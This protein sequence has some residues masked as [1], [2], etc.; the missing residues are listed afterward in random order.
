M[1]QRL[2]SLLLRTYPRAFRR[3]HGDEFRA[4]ILAQRRRAGSGLVAGV[5]FWL[6]TLPDLVLAAT[7]L[8]RSSRDGIDDPGT[9]HPRAALPGGGDLLHSLLHDA[10]FAARALRATPL[11][12]FAIIAT[13]GLGIGLNSAIFSVV[14]AV[15]L[16]PFNYPA[17]EELVYF[18][19][20]GPAADRD[21]LSFSGGMVNQLRDSVDGFETIAA[22]TTIQQNLTG[23]PTPEQVQVGWTSP[24]LFQ[25][26][27]A[28][29][30]LGRTFAI[31]EPA[32][33]AILS[34]RVWQNTLSSDPE[35][36]GRTVEL[37]GVPYTI[38]GV[39]EPGFALHVGTSALEIDIWKTPD[40]EWANGDIWTSFG[41]Q[42]ALLTVIGRLKDGTSMETAQLEVDAFADSI[43]GEHSEYAE[44]EWNIWLRPLR[45]SVVF[46]IR[47]TL[48]ILQGA[49]GFVLLIACANVANLLVLRASRREREMGLRMALG[50]GRL[51]IV[52]LMLVESV[53][54]ALAGGVA[55]MLFAWGGIRLITSIAAA[56]IP[57]FA[58]I[59]VDIRVL[60]FTALLALG[61]ALGFGLAPALRA[62]RG[63]LSR[64]TR[65]VKSTE[66][67][68]K[69]RL[70]RGLAVS[71]ISLSLVLLIGAGL[72][73]TSL[74]RLQQVQLGV[75]EDD[76]L[77]FSIS[78]PGTRYEWPS[79]TGQFFTEFEQRIANLPGATAAGVMW[80]LPLSTARW[81]GRFDGGQIEPEAQ[82]NVRY[83]LATAP[84]F[85]AIGIRLA[86]GR[87]YAADDTEFAVVISNSLA[88]R[89]WPGESPLGRT[90]RSD[91]WGRGMTEFE[92][93]G[94][95]SDVRFTG[96]REPVDDAIYFDARRW[97]WVDWEVDVVLRGR[98]DPVSLV[99]AVRN[100][101]AA[102]DAEIPAAEVRLMRSYVDD[103]LASG[104]FALQLLGLF[105]SV[106]VT[107]ALIGLYGVLS[108]GVAARTR[109]IG[110][111]MAL[112]SSRL[113]VLR[114]VVGSGLRLAI[115]GLAFGVA[116]AWALTRF[117]NAFLF[118]VAPTDATIFATI[119]AIMLLVALVASYLP[120]RRAT[121]LDPATVLRTD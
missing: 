107:L 20:R 7:R 16:E 66:G 69:Q 72:L 32:S 99:P 93:V 9:L 71:Q 65:G 97:S 35:V 60:G 62:A 18:H 14:N 15:L 21:R 45:E 114:M 5:K 115:I 6:R 98:A 22:A 58:N 51:A 36:I 11:A 30:V 39:A 3:R 17:P 10:R 44:L 102:L 25:M 49:V 105:A 76:L 80:P 63:D 79:G 75:Q 101:L 111:R 81:G 12:T 87:L 43:R 56:Q 77:T 2:A 95:V 109:E 113:Q 27:G 67:A 28:E 48:W 74:A 55:A 119:S 85:D 64:T 37:D 41:P 116:G 108:S 68:G 26:L 90:L 106:A 42:F 88:Q 38:V 78:L 47:P 110:I 40:A 117:L 92:V 86:D 118:G 1:S 46:A 57:Q 112:G 13:L 29:P 24:N 73:V 34:H 52:R 31:D 53:M 23:I 19:A 82:D 33:M 103:G 96:L 83:V 70:S 121:R 104:R 84:V 50:S 54:L 100:E 120:A 4:D 91:P 94:V 8:R 61:C 89:A 59:A